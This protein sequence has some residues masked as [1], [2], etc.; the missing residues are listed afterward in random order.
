M[1]YITYEAKGNN[2]TYSC[3]SGYKLSGNKCYKTITEEQ[4]V[5]KYIDITY[6]RYQLRTKQ[7]KKIDIKWSTP[8]D[9]NLINQE[10]NMIRKVTCEF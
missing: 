4:T 5:D 9:Q 1:F 10:Y 2:T 6:Y 8:N 7:D 3:N